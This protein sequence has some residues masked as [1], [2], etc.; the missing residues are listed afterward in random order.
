MGLINLS[1]TWRRS[2]G[3]S[4]ATQMVPMPPAPT[5]ARGRTSPRLSDAQSPTDRTGALKANQFVTRRTSSAEDGSQPARGTCPP[6]PSEP[7]VS[8][9]ASAAHPV[10]YGGRRDVDGSQ[11]A[12]ARHPRG[13]RRP[14]AMG[15]SDDVG[16]VASGLRLPP[17]RALPRNPHPTGVP[18]P[19]P[20]SLRRPRSSATS[21]ASAPGH[22]R[23]RASPRA[24]IVARTLAMVASP[25]G[26]T[27][28]SDERPWGDN[29]LSWSVLPALA[30]DL[31]YTRFLFGLPGFR[32]AR[33]GPADVEGF[34]SSTMSAIA[35]SSPPR[36]PSPTTARTEPPR[37]PAPSSSPSTPI[38]SSSLQTRGPTTS[39]RARRPPGR[40]PRYGATGRLPFAPCPPRSVIVRACPPRP[41]GC[42]VSIEIAPPALPRTTAW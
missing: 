8:S 26:I 29:W 20:D 13:A 38:A 2:L 41:S 22:Q 27:R 28:F 34:G 23:G 9:T 24:S 18:S 15:G 12:S 21:F 19:R 1:A 5:R 3:L 11:R 30:V 42:D 31:V 32:R 39:G 33:Y 25:W 37:S 14:R 35:V 4:V 16:P 17:R 36:T 10:R 6:L 40:S 7:A